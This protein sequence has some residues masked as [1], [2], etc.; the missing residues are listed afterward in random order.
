VTIAQQSAMSNQGVRARPPAVS[1]EHEL[2]PVEDP[3]PAW[4]IAKIAGLV[5]LAALGMTLAVAI[6]VGGALF[7]LMSFG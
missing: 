6:V 2:I 3:T 1:S 7:A 4:T 5:A